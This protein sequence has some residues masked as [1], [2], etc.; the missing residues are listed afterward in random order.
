ML[1]SIIST[2]LESTGLDGG[3]TNDKT[4]SICNG[5]SVLGVESDK[6]NGVDVRIL[7]CDTLEVR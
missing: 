5:V 2:L 4:N 6:H 7:H 1:G 3:F